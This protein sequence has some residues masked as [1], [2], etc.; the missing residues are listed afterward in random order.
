MLNQLRKAEKKFKKKSPVKQISTTTTTATTNPYHK[1]KNS[2]YKDH[3]RIGSE[4]LDIED[5]SLIHSDDEEFNDSDEELHNNHINNHNNHNNINRNEFSPCNSIGNSTKNS[6]KTIKPFSYN[7]NDDINK[8][9]EEKEPLQLEQQPNDKINSNSNNNMSS[10]KKQSSSAERIVFR[11]VSE[12]ALKIFSTKKSSSCDRISSLEFPSTKNNIDTNKININNGSRNV[13]INNTNNTNNNTIR[14]VPPLH[15]S[16]NQSNSNELTP[17][18]TIPS[19][20]SNTSEA[21][22]SF[23]SPKKP[24]GTS[25][26]CYYK[27]YYHIVTGM[28]IH[29]RSLLRFGLVIF[30]ALIAITVPNVGL[31]IALS[32]ASSGAAL[33]LIIPPL[34]DMKIAETRLNWNRLLVNIISIIIGTLGA[35]IGTYVAL[36]DI[37][38]V[39]G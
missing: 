37:M 27:C 26:T 6:T 10:G 32:G 8:K 34:V 29:A 39:Y 38:N 21:K 22:W 36:Q 15:S 20:N 28:K 12:S 25:T 35:I 1:R 2:K 33:S 4:E 5:V 11:A 7:N 31:L 18:K 16:S 30:T 24:P 19:S 13:Q 23:F 9:K 17:L 3:L 14:T